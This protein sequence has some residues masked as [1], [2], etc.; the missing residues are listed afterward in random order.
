MDSAPRIPHQS[1][2]RLTIEAHLRYFVHAPAELLFAVEVAQLS[3]QRLVTDQ[4]TLTGTGP[5]T[6]APGEEGIGRRTW[7]R[8]DGM[9]EARYTA[10]VDVE[11][12]SAD[13]SFLHAAP[14]STLPASV[15]AHLWPS[16]YCDS[17][18]FEPWVRRRIGH[19][20]GGAKVAAIAE[21]V[22][23]NMAY[24]PCASTQ[25]TTAGDSFIRREGVCRDYAHLFIAMVRAADIPARIVGAYGYGVHPPDF[26]A[27]AEVW[28]DDAWHL[29]DPTGLAPIEGIVRVCVGRDATDIG[30]LT[31][32]GTA[33][34]VEQRVSVSRVAVTS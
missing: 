23:A 15:T 25:R 12:S 20:T 29:V 32:F 8:G 26:H 3:D 5:L 18:L 31:I 13:L 33:D 7:T 22:S 28:L 30:F 34:L 11:R 24:V 17:D 9:V 14:L 6:P 2:M 10:T 21:W 19:L 1:R 16:R 27:V 4:L